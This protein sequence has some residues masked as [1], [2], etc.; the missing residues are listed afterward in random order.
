M[1]GSSGVLLA[2]EQ[3]MK[4]QGYSGQEI[5]DVF[6]EASRQAVSEPVSPET[7]KVFDLADSFISHVAKRVSGEAI[8]AFYGEVT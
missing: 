1:F 2:L 4:K 8:R 5:L 3:R 7:Q 6:N